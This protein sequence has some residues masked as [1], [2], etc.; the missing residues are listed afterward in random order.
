MFE[1]AVGYSEELEAEFAAE[2]IIE[3]CKESFKDQQPD[4]GLLF[5]TID[6]EHQEILNAIIKTWPDIHLIGC[7][8]DGEIS[9]SKGF[10]EDS[11]Q[12]MLISSDEVDI[13]AGVGKDISNNLEQACKAAVENAQEKTDK[14]PEICITVLDP[15]TA[16]SANV[17]K[18][19]SEELGVNIPL[20]GAAAGDQWQFKQTYQ[21]Y[22]GEVLSDSVPILL[23]SGKFNHSFS[24]AC[25]WKQ[26][27]KPGTVTLAEGNVLKEVDGEPAI[28]FYKKYLGEQS[29][30]SGEFP[31]AILD[32]NEGIDYLRATLGDVD[33][34]GAITFFA[35]VPENAKIQITAPDR[36]GILDGC[37]QSIMRTKENYP[38]GC[39]PEAAIVFSCSARKLL[40]GTRTNEEY[41][42]IRSLI[43]KNIPLI[44]FYGYG[45]IGPCILSDGNNRFH[46]ETFVSLFLGS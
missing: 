44:G 45:E 23:F 14:K 17:V 37:K 13:T 10:M 29:D 2:E 27:G 30:P 11:T 39:E 3:Q 6:I 42:L 31:I 35:A 19:L 32:E 20:L 12:L 28:N 22:K 18:L 4:A 24:T 5:T 40:L 26:L 41:K 43:G 25:G 46:N 34:N 1:I 21:F 15:L 8:T 7:T 38:S 36:D 16:D 9:S 33:N